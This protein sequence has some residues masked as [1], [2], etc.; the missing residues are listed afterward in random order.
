MLWT[1]L[2]EY[3]AALDKSGELRVVRGANW[4]EEIG[5]ITELIT[6]RQGPALLFDEI[7]SYPKGYRVASNLFTTTNRTAL[8][9]GMGNGENLADRWA[10][11]I[12]GF[13]PVPPEYVASG[14]ILEN[15]LIGKDVDLFKFPTPKW[16]E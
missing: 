6:E 1:D 13:R 4:E 16:H 14:P 3:L 7:P 2:R 11:K 12:R 10:A 15:V 8:A 5:G 9:L